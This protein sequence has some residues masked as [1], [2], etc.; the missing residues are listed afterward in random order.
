M[1]YKF[2]WYFNK[3]K[4][5]QEELKWRKPTYTFHKGNILLIHDFKEYCSLLLMIGALLKDAK[6]TRHIIN[7]KGL[8][9]Y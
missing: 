5:C 7:G 6:D 8:N 9:D 1:N 2:D 3:T 4:K